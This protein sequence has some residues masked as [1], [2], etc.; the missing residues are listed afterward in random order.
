MLKRSTAISKELQIQKVTY[1][2]L[3]INFFK[4]DVTN[5]RVIKMNLSNSYFHVT[6]FHV[7]KM[8]LSNTYFH[9]FLN[10]TKIMKFFIENYSVQTTPTLE[11]SEKIF[12][13]LLDKMAFHNTQ[14]LHTFGN[15]RSAIN[16]N[17]KKNDRKDPSKQKL[18]IK[19]IKIAFVSDIF[20]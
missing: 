2:E 13:K 4:H 7:I 6:N 8:N 14:L 1:T 20:Y 11:F 12:R 9:A 15:F 18:S 16:V 3:L 19:T 10:P 5:F 17:L